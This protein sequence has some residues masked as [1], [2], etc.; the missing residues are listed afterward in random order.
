MEKRLEEEKNVLKRAD[1]EFNAATEKVGML[2]AQCN[3]MKYEIPEIQ[4]E[5]DR[6]RRYDKNIVMRL[7]STPFS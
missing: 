5:Y 7:K 1:D 3:D 2:E 6:L 4:R